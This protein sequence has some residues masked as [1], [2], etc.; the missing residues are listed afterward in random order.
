MCLPFSMKTEACVLCDQDEVFW[1]ECGDVTSS[2]S[3][4]VVW[5]DSVGSP[6]AAGWECEHC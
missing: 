2:T 1:F 4:Y 6:L 3:C 5:A